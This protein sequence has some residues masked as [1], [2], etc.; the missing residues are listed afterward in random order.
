MWVRINKTHSTYHHS[1]DVT[2]IDFAAPSENYL[3]L[4]NKLHNL[5]KPKL[6]NEITY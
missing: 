6:L 1:T 4:V 2:A 5:T 3:L